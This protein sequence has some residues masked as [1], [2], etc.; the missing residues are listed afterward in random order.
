VNVLFFV[1][2]VGV[3]GVVR[4]VAITADQLVERGHGAALVGLYK[5]DDDWESLWESRGVAVGPLLGPP[6]TKAWAALL[7]LL[8]ATLQLRRLVRQRNVDLLYGYQGQLARLVAWAVTRRL[9][10]TT[11]V[12]G[13]QGSGAPRS[14]G[15]TSWTLVVPFYLCKWVSGS[16]PLLIT[17]SRAGYGARQRQGLRCREMIVIPNG[18][19]ALTFRPDGAARARVRSQW[20]VGDEPVIGIVARLDR[21]KGHDVFLRAAALLGRERPDA[22][23]V[24][25]GDGPIGLRGELQH[26]A[27]E[28]GVASRVVWAGT[29]HDMPAV[30]NALDVLCSAS[31]REG[32]PNVVGEAMACGV[33]CVVTDVGD[34]AMIVGDTGL[35]VPPGRPEA[36][37]GSLSAMLGRLP[38]VD[39]GALRARIVTRFTVEAWVNATE[40]ALTRAAR[41]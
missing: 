32:F 16:V 6:P 23:F 9:P 8:R 31:F 27:G 18:F 3:G 33:P 17:N 14:L 38:E 34:S 35:V 39:R 25:V 29:R 11:L 10:A 28:L 24:V 40:Q 36:L 20:R 12:W 19:D 4:Q 22:R 5:L 21:E 30:Y 15:E 13:G 7:P 1:Q 26:L 37:A 2:H 41:G